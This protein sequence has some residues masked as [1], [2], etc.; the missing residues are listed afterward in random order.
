MILKNM[1]RLERV[2]AEGCG[3]T[4]LAG[5]ANKVNL[6]GIYCARNQIQKV[7]LIP[8]TGSWI[9]VDLRYNEL[10]DLSG[11]PA[12]HYGFLALHGNKD[13]DLR[14]I[15]APEGMLIDY[16]SLD[17]QDSLDKAE[18]LQ[19]KVTRLYICGCPDDRVVAMENR[20]GSKLVLTDEEKLDRAIES[21]GMDPYKWPEDILD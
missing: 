4:S 14:T 21:E 19:K 6:A 17:W 10:T 7:S 2:R 16:V 12:N 13:V 18:S 3:L 5:I 8:D 11:L 20:M 15:P 9:S 1:S